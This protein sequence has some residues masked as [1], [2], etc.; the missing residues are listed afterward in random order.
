MELWLILSSRRPLSNRNQSIDLLCKSLDWFLYDNGL[1]HERVNDLLVA[2]QNNLR[3]LLEP[4]Q[5]SMLK[6][7]QNGETH[8]NNSSSICRQII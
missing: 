8:S 7:S 5:T 2:I 6:I 3:S 1:R 4:S